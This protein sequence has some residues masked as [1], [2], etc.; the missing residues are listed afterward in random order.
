MNALSKSFELMI[1][2]LTLAQYTQQ[3][4]AEWTK[5]SCLTTTPYIHNKGVAAHPPIFPS[6]I[7]T[8]IVKLKEMKWWRGDKVKYQFRVNLSL[9]NASMPVSL[10]CDRFHQF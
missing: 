4:V 5:W 7:L 8:P 3:E 6:M 1:K 9:K 2:S 10:I